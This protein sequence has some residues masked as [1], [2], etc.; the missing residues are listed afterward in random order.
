MATILPDSGEE[1][2]HWRRLVGK[3]FTAKR[4][5]ALRPAMAR[6]A[7]DLIDDMVEGGAAR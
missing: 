3:W 6:I 1:H 7:D 2:Q 5:T 4:M